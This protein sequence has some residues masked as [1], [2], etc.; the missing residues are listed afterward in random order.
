MCIPYSEKATIVA[1][2]AAKSSN[3]DDSHSLGR[4]RRRTPFSQ[5]SVHNKSD[6]SC[7]LGHFFSGEKLS[8]AFLSFVSWENG[9]DSR[10]F[11]SQLSF[12]PTRIS[13][14]MGIEQRKRG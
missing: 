12:F 3:Y 10:I 2:F 1:W 11:P 5:A 4:K 6:D 13:P 14:K 7:P 9:Q 8:S